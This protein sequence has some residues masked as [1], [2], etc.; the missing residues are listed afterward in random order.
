MPLSIASEQ[1][2]ISLRNCN[3]SRLPVNEFGNKR[4]KLWK[5]AAFCGKP[6]R[7]AVSQ[8]LPG[9]ADRVP[10]APGPAFGTWESTNSNQPA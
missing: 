5:E 4:K 10:G 7:G 2:L 9:R 3:F 6:L 1:P 8:V